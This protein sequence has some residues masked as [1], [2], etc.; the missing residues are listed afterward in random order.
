MLLLPLLPFYEIFFKGKGEEKERDRLRIKN[1]NLLSPL[2][3]R[4]TR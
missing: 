4:Y 3:K 1:I 2:L